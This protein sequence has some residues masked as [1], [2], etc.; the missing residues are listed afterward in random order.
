[1]QPLVPT[2]RPL[3]PAELVDWIDHRDQIHTEQLGQEYALATT[4]GTLLVTGT[5]P[6]HGPLVV[7]ADRSGV[8]VG[9]HRWAAAD[10]RAALVHAPGLLSADEERAAREEL[11]ARTPYA[12]HPM[13]AKA[14][15]ART[16]ATREVGARILLDVAPGPVVIELEGVLAFQVARLHGALWLARGADAEAD[17]AWGPS[18]VDT[19]PWPEPLQEFLAAGGDL[20]AVDP[21]A[22]PR[23]EAPLRLPVVGEPDALRPEESAGYARYRLGLLGT[24]PTTDLLRVTET[25][26]EAP[27]KGRRGLR[28]LFGSSSRQVEKERTLRAGPDGVEIDGEHHGWDAVSRL[29]VRIG[30]LRLADT[31]TGFLREL[32]HLLPDASNQYL[33]EV[34][35]LSGGS[36]HLVDGEIELDA[37]GGPRTLTLAGERVFQLASWLPVVRAAARDHGVDADWE[38]PAWY[39]RD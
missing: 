22:R 3:S 18:D 13:V 19:D 16:D 35:L 4:S 30:E 11:V 31:W 37:G 36:H 21:P 26:E 32:R 28:G 27:P 23:T 29:M 9:D 15:L 10:I 8:S 12:S 2:S 34:L 39:V 1:M 6:E 25:I 24:P 7:R 14:M 5:A 33:S 38:L 20:A 17:I